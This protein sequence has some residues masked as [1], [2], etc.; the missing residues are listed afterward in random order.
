[1]RILINALFLVPN[2]VGGSETYLRSLIN[3]LA[4]IDLANEYVLCVGP[5]AAATFPRLSEQWRLVVSPMQSA[6]R[7]G[8]LM[9]EQT[10]VPRVAEA[11]KADVIHS[12]GYTAPL[13]SRAR[14]VT[15]IHDM[16]YKRHPE[17]LSWAERT[18][19]ATLIPRV[20]H[21]SRRVIALTEA[22]R[23][24]IVRWTGV[25]ARKVTVVYSAAR[26]DWPGEPSA[27]AERV[28]AAGVAEPFVLSVAAAYPHKNL[29]RLVGA[30]PVRTN[31]DALITLVIVGLKGRASAEVRAASAGRPNQVRVL[32]WVDDALLASLYRRSLALAFPS[33]YEGFGL[34]ILEAMALGVPVVTSHMGAMAEVAG[35]AAELVNPFEVES[36]RLGMQRVICDQAY[37]HELR[38]R[39]VRRAAQFTWTATAQG[40]LRVYTEAAARV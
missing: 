9:L 11:V 33:L 25:P 2:Q 7:P 34:P 22:A 18:V 26:S 23:T 17:D 16:N 40:T 31:D 3:E 32:G 29:G 36:I 27:D 5:E 13:I 8:R 21:T 15:T 35:D 24:D 28:A 38:R 1:L 20:A 19:Y 6:W 39:G 4:S 14:R 10:W 30:L 12:P 37:R